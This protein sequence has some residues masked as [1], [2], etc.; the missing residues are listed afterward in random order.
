MSEI[1]EQAVSA[2]NKAYPIIVDGEA[3]DLL[4]G[5]EL[6]ATSLNLW[7]QVGTDQ[8]VAIG[9]WLY[10]RALHKAGS[11]NLAMSAATKAV[12]HAKTDG[13]D[14]LVASC[15]EGLTRASKGIDQYLA[16]FEETKAAISAIDDPKDRQIIQ[17]QFA[18]LN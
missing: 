18:D 6:A 3:G 2:Y 16:L 17:D 14:W 12:S 5:L 13:T 9:Y 7:R 8:N 1:R 10:S 11:A 4:E 15:L